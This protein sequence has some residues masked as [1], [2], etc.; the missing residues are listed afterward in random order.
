MAFHGAMMD[1]NEA[2]SSPQASSRLDGAFHALSPAKKSPEFVDTASLSSYFFNSENQ[3]EDLNGQISTRNQKNLRQFLMQASQLQR[4]P[5]KM[6]DLLIK[7]QERIFEKEMRARLS[8]QNL[9][10]R[11]YPKMGVQASGVRSPFD[12]KF[13]GAVSRNTKDHFNSTT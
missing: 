1:P 9:S 6:V 4:R 13:Q 10:L 2:H 12:K 5:N 8:H 7:D 11:K 3:H